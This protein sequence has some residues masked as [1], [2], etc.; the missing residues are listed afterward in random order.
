MAVIGIFLLMFY[1]L[2]LG[3]LYILGWFIFRMVNLSRGKTDFSLMWFVPA[4]YLFCSVVLGYAIL[5]MIDF[6][7]MWGGDTLPYSVRFGNYREMVLLTNIT[8][9]LFPIL[10]F[11]KHNAIRRK[12]KSSQT[13]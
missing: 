12:A 4:T 5:V 11:F 7:T 9:P 1:A 6:N 3:E 10:A 2:V 8:T 13:V